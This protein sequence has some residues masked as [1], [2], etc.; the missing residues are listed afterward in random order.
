[1]T[2]RL[3]LYSESRRAGRRCGPCT[4]CCT[5][6]GIPELDK[7]GFERCPKLRRRRPEGCSI[8]G[9]RPN[10]CREWSCG[11]L[12]GIGE[13]SDRPDRLGLIIDI[14]FSD[15]LGCYMVKLFE[16]RPGAHKTDRA[17]EL[18]KAMGEVPS[19]AILISPGDRR[20]LLGGSPAEVARALEILS[21]GGVIVP[22]ETLKP[23][24]S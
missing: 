7:P 2:R 1:M 17:F 4:A 6:L 14:E 10:S 9:S 12:L 13:A 18:T 22:K 20:K 19:V 15:T 21:A 5:A 11:W 24:E 8:Y 3:P 23:E 16:L